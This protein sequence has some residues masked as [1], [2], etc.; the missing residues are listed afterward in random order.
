MVVSKDLFS[1]YCTICLCDYVAGP[2]QVPTA[3]HHLENMHIVF[4]MYTHIIT[5]GV[6]TIEA[7]GSRTDPDGR[8]AQLRWRRGTLGRHGLYC[9]ASLRGSRIGCSKQM[10]LS[11]ELIS[12]PAAGLKHFVLQQPSALKLM[13]FRTVA[14][15]VPTPSLWK[16]LKRPS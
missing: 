12:F 2:G 9:D 13:P 7:T 4:I 11:C 5:R 1:I 10:V 8:L 3:C 16:V 6:I 14:L 15:R